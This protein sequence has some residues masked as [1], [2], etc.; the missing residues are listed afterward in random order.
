VNRTV[1]RLV[2]WSTLVVPAFFA[3][4]VNSVREGRSHLQGSGLFFWITVLVSVLCIALAHGLPQRIRQVPA[5]REATA[6][7]RLVC[8]WALCEGAAL[9]PL[10]AWIIS[11]DPRLLGVCIVDLLALLT[12]YPSEARWASLLPGEPTPARW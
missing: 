4:V 2:W 10:V 8:G 9:F 7:I 1:A 12:L 3:A 11:D 6:F 5:G